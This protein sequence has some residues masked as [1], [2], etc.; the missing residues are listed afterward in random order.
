MLCLPECSVAVGSAQ[1]R[2]MAV[3]PP[4]S[5]GSPDSYRTGC[6]FLSSLL[7]LQRHR[8]DEAAQ[9]SRRGPGSGES[10]SRCL[11]SPVPLGGSF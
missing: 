1:A 7:F 10:G 11:L 8:G 6:Q 2:S 5:P 4:A 3:V 9:G